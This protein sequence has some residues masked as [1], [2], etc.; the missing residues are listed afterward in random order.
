MGALLIGL[1]GGCILPFQ[2][3]VNANLNRRMG[4]PFVA[5]FISF[6]IGTLFLALL[7]LLTYHKIYIPFGMLAGEP[8]WIW[9]GGLFGVTY[10]TCNI[11]LM[12]RLGAV[13]TVVF[14]V[15]G[16]ILSGLVIDQFGLF[17][18]MEIPMSASRALGAALVLGGVILISLAKSANA[19]KTGSEKK[20]GAGVWV[21]RLLGVF[22]GCLSG[23]QIAINGYLGKCMEAPLIAALISFIVGTLSVFIL[24]IFLR[25][26]VNKKSE[27]TEKFPAWIWIGGTIGAIYVFCNAYIA[28]I[29]GTGM[30]AVVVQTGQMC[31]ST[32]IDHFGLVRSAKN[33]ITVKKV[34]GLLL[35]IIGAAIIRLI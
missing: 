26:R 20:A 27:L 7:V 11:L 17:R 32:T 22:A 1:F 28:P 2:T 29:I 15:S 31:G 14:P 4:S 8:F 35:M 3:S 6:G 18:A 19:K 10:P 9:L 24:L 21:W 25:P 5:S 16:L 12:P 30:A 33:A 13:Q 34:I 23:M